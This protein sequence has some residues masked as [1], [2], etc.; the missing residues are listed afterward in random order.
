MAKKK[1]TY[2]GRGGSGGSAGGPNSGGGPAPNGK[3]RVRRR[4]RNP[5][6][7][8]RSPDARNTEGGEPADVPSDAPLEEC[9]G[10]LELHPNGYGFLRSPS[11]NYSRERTDPFVP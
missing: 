7:D 3:P 6:A 4:R 8:Q 11:H 5:N 10:I 1:R 9:Q 2:R